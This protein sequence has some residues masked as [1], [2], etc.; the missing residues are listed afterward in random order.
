MPIAARID[1][2]GKLAWIFL[3]IV[4]FIVW[5]PLGLATLGFIISPAD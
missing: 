3:M 5:W 2:F 1:E 4:G